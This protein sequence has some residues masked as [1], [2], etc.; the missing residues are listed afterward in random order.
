MTNIFVHEITC[1][2]CGEESALVHNPGELTFYTVCSNPLCV[3]AD[4]DSYSVQRARFEEA[5]R[6]D[7]FA[8]GDTFWLEGFQFEVVGRERG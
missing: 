7:D 2:E 6:Q 5:L 8:L 4:S 1:Q 3:D